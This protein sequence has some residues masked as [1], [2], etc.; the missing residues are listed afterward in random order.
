MQ[1]VDSMMLLLNDNLSNIKNNVVKIAGFDLDFTIIKTKSG[2]P[3][4]TSIDDY[5]MFT[6]IDVIKNRFHSLINDNFVIVVFSNQKGLEKHFTKDEYTKKILAIIDMI[7]KDETHISCGLTASR[8]SLTTG[9]D[10][11]INWMFALEDD[12]YRKP[13]TGMFEY[14]V[15]HIKK[16]NKDLVIDIDNSFYC[17]D[18]AG[19]VYDKK[20]KDF[21]YT[22]MYFAHNCKL[23]FY[24]PE[25]FYQFRMAKKY[26]IVHPYQDFDPNKQ[27][28]HNAKNYN[29]ITN[30]LNEY[31][32]QS[33]K[34]G[35]LLCIIMVG[36]PGSGKSTMRRR[37][38]E[39]NQLKNNLFV[40]SPDEKT[41]PKDL[42][43]TIN[44]QNILFDATNSSFTKHRTKYYHEL[45]HKLYTYLILH[46]DFDK[47]LSK[48]MN[49]T[50]TQKTI[51]T[52]TKGCLIPD[53]AYNIYY[54]NYE[55]PIDDIKQLDDSY[56]LKVIKILDISHVINCDEKLSDEYFMW[57]DL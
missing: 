20:T 32:D 21:S 51:K 14:F 18:S 54:K 1:N 30:Q 49:H 55:D 52:V 42:K 12:Y 48:H 9:K 22:D 36:A 47:K 24:T 2:K 53:I 39:L 8:T 37:L 33:I 38:L 10:I 6:D 45:D 13:M 17:G 15:N 29:E 7:G 50:R 27:F 56:K 4:P 41:S 35:K 16:I 26:N 28:V 40:F 3:L 11:P 34:D 31:I 44:K 23:K 43:K 57:Y 46:F 5:Q 19:R 25:E